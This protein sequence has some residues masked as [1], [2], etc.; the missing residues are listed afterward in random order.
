MYNT[1]LQF[2]HR[3]PKCLLP[4]PIKEVDVKSKILGVT[5]ASLIPFIINAN[6]LLIFGIIKTKRN[7]FTS[8]QILFLTLLSGDLFQSSLKQVF[9]D[10]S[11]YHVGYSFMC[12]IS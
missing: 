11:N 6:L 7:K 8:S 5:H 1:T 9:D 4:F 3:F 2:R 12:D 10:I